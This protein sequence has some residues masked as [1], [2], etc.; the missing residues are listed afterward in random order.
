MTPNYPRR[1]MSKRTILVAD[2]VPSI[3]GEAPQIEVEPNV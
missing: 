1:T 2:L 3:G